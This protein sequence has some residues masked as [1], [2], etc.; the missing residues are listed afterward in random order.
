VLT[1][2]AMNTLPVAMTAPA[3]RLLALV[4]A[5]GGDVFAG[6]RSLAAALDMST[7]AL[8]DLLVAVAVTDKASITPTTR[9]T[10]IKL[11]A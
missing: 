10:R 6:Q 11:A 5:Q 8:N 9:G 4:K 3:E 2:A 7:G 1:V